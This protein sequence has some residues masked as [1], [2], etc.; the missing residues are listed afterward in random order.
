M[1]KDAFPNFILQRALENGSKRMKRENLIFFLQFYKLEI[2]VE[3]K[4]KLN[5]I[6]HE[7]FAFLGK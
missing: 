2:K 5:E 6:M 7:N 4:I 3:E 1:R